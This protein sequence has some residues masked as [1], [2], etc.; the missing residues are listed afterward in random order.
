MSIFSRF[1]KIGQ[2]KANQIIDGLEKPELMLEQA[3]KDKEKQIR[4]AKKAIMSCIATERETKALLEKE[5]GLKFQWEQKAEAALKAGK[6][7]LAVQALNRS[8]EHDQKVTAMQSNWQ[9]QKSNVDA[10]KLDV[11]KLDDDLSEFKR[12]KDFIIAQSKAADVKK[13]IYEAKAKITKKHDTDDLIARMKA[14]AEKTRFEADAAEDVANTFEGKDE[15][16]KQFEGLD[17]GTTSVSVQNKL[18]AMKAK[19]KQNG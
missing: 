16:E 8:T 9:L 17:S 4:E 12:N 11:Q 10:L 19:L 18:E 2:A 3:I 15:L 5:K 7:D 1:F 6:E 14:K 13:S